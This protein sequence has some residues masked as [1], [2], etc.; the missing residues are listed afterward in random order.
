MKISNIF[1]P[2]GISSGGM[3]ALIEQGLMDFDPKTETFFWVWP[4]GPRQ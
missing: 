1:P 4:A 3:Q 2:K